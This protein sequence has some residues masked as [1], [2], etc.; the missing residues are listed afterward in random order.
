M[1][2]SGTYKSV[3]ITRKGGPEVLQVISND[4]RPPV[5]NEVRIKVICTGVGF[6]DVI[7]RYGYY[8][9]APKI[10]FAP[11]YEIVGIVDAVGDGV[12]TVKTGDR[13]AALTVHGGYA[14][15]IYLAPEHLVAV[16][17]SL[18]AAE[19]LCLILNYVTAYQML[20]REASIKQGQKIFITGAA[21][22]VGT[23]LLQLGKVAGVETFGT[24]SKSKHDFVKSQGGV[25]IDYQT[26]D[27]VS[28]VKSHTGDMGVDAAFDALGG[29]YLWKCYQTLRAGGTLVSFGLTASV[30]NAKSDNLIAFGSFGLIGLLTMLPDGKKV[31]FYGITALYRKNPQPFKE[32]LSKLFHLLAEKKLQPVIAEKFS[33]LDAAKANALL[34]QGKVSGKIIL[35]ND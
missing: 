33:M 1:P 20:H 25:P 30:K 29:S 24:A 11:G 17:G 10:P 27:I 7:M 5:K 21:G 15:Y 19:A 26:G 14:E 31:K 8:P 2:N 35:M 18:D 9:F 13:V 32:D 16:P 23:A 4:L 12:S 22:G 34:E 3:I 6:T 28:A